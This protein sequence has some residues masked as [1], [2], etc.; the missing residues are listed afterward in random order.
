MSLPDK[1]KEAGLNFVEKEDSVW[2]SG[3]FTLNDDRTQLFFLNK[4]AN[5]FCGHKEYDFM[6]VVGPADD[7]VN[8]KKA[9]EMAGGMKRGAIVVDS[10]GMICLKMEIPADM[11]GASAFSHVQGVCITADELEK[12]IFGGD[13]W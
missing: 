11:D 4:S 6:S 9:C 3:S 2:L 13:D 8:V 5:E 7:A 1:L 12:E 10:E